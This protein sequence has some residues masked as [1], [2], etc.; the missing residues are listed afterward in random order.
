MTIAVLALA[1][2]LVA[3]I[4][5]LHI[6]NHTLYSLIRDYD[7]SFFVLGELISKLHP[8]DVQF[9]FCNV[10]WK[11]NGRITVE[12]IANGKI[13]ITSTIHIEK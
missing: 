8:D 10:F 6:I 12:K 2:I 5:R 4:F 1:I 9:R 7:H 11:E 3:V 13:I